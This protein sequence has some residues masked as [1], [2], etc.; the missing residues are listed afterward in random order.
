MFNNIIV[1][2]YQMM[3]FG[4]WLTFFSFLVQKV[5]GFGMFCFH[6]RYLRFESDN[7]SFILLE[8]FFTFELAKNSITHG[9]LLIRL[10]ES[11]KKFR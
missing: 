8:S 6:E 5:F 3:N 9:K 2:F 4:Q 11:L 1:I 10:F 7:L